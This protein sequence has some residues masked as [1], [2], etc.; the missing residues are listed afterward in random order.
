MKH[1][2][3][4]WVGK[5]PKA[6]VRSLGPS[7]LK[8]DIATHSNILAW[9]FPWIEEPSRLQSIGVAQSQTRLKRPSTHCCMECWPHR[10]T[11]AS[12]SIRY[13][14]RCIRLG[15]KH[16]LTHAHGH[17]PQICRAKVH[18]LYQER[19]FLSCRIEPGR[20]P[21]CTGRASSLSGSSPR[22]AEFPIHLP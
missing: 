6:R 15:S 17:H 22:K 1:R 20:G 16:A 7:P 13:A 18:R 2:F 14:Q 8:K 12:L 5:A 3:D 11:C 9:R 21:L 19:P 4:L 10:R